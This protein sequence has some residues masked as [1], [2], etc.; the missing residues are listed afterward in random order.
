MFSLLKFRQNS[1]ILIPFRYGMVFKRSFKKF[2]IFSA[3][4]LGLFKISLELFKNASS[5]LFFDL[6][7]YPN[8]FA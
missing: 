5:V 1:F 6:L 3:I 2:F 4:P 8:G 7:G